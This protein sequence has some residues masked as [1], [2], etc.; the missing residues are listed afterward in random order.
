GL[1]PDRPADRGDLR[2][3]LGDLDADL[4][5]EALRRSAGGPIANRSVDNGSVHPSLTS[6]ARRRPRH[7]GGV[8]STA[9]RLRSMAPSG[10]GERHRAAVTVGARAKRDAKAGANAGRP[11]PVT[12]S[13]RVP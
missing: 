8:E 12:C 7:R 3:E 1:R 13:G 4:P 5:L 2:A 9:V 11:Q 6:D 10:Y